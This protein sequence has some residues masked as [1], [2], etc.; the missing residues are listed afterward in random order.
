L[1]ASVVVT[2][3]ITRIARK[4]LAKRISA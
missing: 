4:A 1:L 2:V 3:Y